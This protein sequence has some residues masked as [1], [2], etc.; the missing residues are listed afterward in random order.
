[1]DGQTWWP[2]LQAF[3][4]AGG[5]VVEALFFVCWML[6]AL[7]LERLWFCWRIYPRDRALAT[8][9]L[10]V[11]DLRLALE[12]VWPLIRSLISLCPLI[13]LLGTVTGMIQVF[14]VLAMTG[15]ANPKLMAA[16]VASATLPTLAGILIAIVGLLVCTPLQ[17]WSQR[18][19]LQL[20]LSSP[21]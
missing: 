3:L 14:D 4:Q 18:Q 19:A 12:G 13:G 6:W 9:P 21:V 7:L 17:R 2:Y 20:T 5:P 8:H 16:G 11:V 15:T 10:Q 1:M